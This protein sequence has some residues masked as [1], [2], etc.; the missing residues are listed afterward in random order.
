[1]CGTMAEDAVVG[2]QMPAHVAGHDACG[3]IADAAIAHAVRTGFDERYGP[4]GAARRVERAIDSREHVLRAAPFGMPKRIDGLPARMACEGAVSQAVADE[5]RKPAVERAA[6]P[7]IAVLV[8]SF[9]REREAA[10]PPGSGRTVRRS[11]ELRCEHCSLRRR[12]HVDAGRQPRDCAE[13]GARRACRR[14]AVRE[15]LV[16]VGDAGALVHGDE[17][18]LAVRALEPARDRQDATTGMAEQIRR[19]LRRD[20]RDVAAAR[21]VE[22]GASG[23]LDGAAPRLGYARAVEQPYRARLDHRQ[24]VTL[25]CVP[26]PTVDSIE[27]SFI[28]RFEP[29]RPR[30]SPL[31]VV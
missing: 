2:D 25:T 1:P 19:E 15:A 30:P 17:Q 29:D 10:D 16:E 12:V 13:P 21:I 6:I 9:L 4:R 11:H 20:D 18:E 27:K 28:K 3:N 31:P 8:L 22:A 14:I 23:V 24:R 26:L 5:H 7:R